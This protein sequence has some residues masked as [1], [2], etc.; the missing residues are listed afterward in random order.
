MDSKPF[1]SDA[2]IFRWAWEQRKKFNTPPDEPKFSISEVKALLFVHSD[3]TVTLKKIRDYDFI[4]SESERKPGGHRKY[5][6]SDVLLLH[7]MLSGS[8]C[9]GREKASLV[10]KLYQTVRR[11][12]NR[13]NPT[14][15]DNDPIN[16]LPEDVDSVLN[17]AIMNNEFWKVEQVISLMNKI[18]VFLKFNHYLIQRG[19]AFICSDDELIT[20]KRF[21]TEIKISPPVI[22][23][24]SVKKAFYLRQYFLAEK[25]INDDDY[26][27]DKSVIEKLNEELNKRIL[28]WLLEKGLIMNL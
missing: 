16:T 4:F 14:L 24:K 7:L 19:Y 15:F 9:F 11:Q 8:K 13:H 25:K 5:S 26:L 20:A 1:T 6:V 23:W 17:K 22:S 2:N 27:K 10:V 18:R 28:D 12:P 3:Q 21:G